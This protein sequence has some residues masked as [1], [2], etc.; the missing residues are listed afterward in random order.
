MT[1]TEFW[2]RTALHETKEDRERGYH[3]GAHVRPIAP[4]TE[5]FDRIWKLRNYRESYNR[6][7]EDAQYRSNRAHADS[8]GALVLHML[9]LAGAI[10]AM[11]RAR[12]EQ[13]RIGMAA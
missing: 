3:R 4:G 8:K 1:G 2:T 13:A 12:M 6:V 9:F 7:I 11:T 10:N 5:A